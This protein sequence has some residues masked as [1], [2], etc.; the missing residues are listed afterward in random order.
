MPIVLDVNDT[1]IAPNEI[2]YM[3][4]NTVQMRGKIFL[5]Q[6][7]IKYMGSYELNVNDKKLRRM[8]PNFQLKI[9]HK[10]M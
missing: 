3:T 6:N 8:L 5:M 1:W 2:F 4:A 7:G 10:W 9:F